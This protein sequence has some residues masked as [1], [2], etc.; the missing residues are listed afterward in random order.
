M[1]NTL[2]LYS[3]IT[4]NYVAVCKHGFAVHELP[5]MAIWRVHDHVPDD[6]KPAQLLLYEVAGGDIGEDRLT[7]VGFKHGGP[8]WP[9]GEHPRLVGLTV[10]GRIFKQRPTIR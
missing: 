6:A 3:T 7:P 2:T 5:A 1:E 10:T 8:V 9:N 4:P